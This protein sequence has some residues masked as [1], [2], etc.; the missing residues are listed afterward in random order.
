[1]NKGLLVAAVLGVGVLG[2]AVYKANQN[3]QQNTTT[4]ETLP[5]SLP[6]IMGG[7]SGYNAIT[8]AASS[9]SFMQPGVDLVATPAPAPINLGDTLAAKYANDYKLG[10]VKAL[11]GNA[12]QISGKIIGERPN[13]GKTGGTVN[14]SLTVGGDVAQITTTL[15]A[16]VL[17][18]VKDPIIT[19]VVV[20]QANIT[21]TTHNNYSTN[22]TQ[23]TNT[24]TTTKKS[25]GLFA[26]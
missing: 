22:Y 20:P 5:L 24:K 6:V 18:R 26:F 19:P 16:D 13:G 17:S 4:S 3:D 2:Y 14:S 15:H 10:L 8:P 11:I 21:T 7:G 25:T 23:I 1:M 12:E 9:S